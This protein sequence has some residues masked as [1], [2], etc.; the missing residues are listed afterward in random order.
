MRRFLLSYKF[1]IVLYTFIII[2]KYIKIIKYII[3]LF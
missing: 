2:L 3:K 1:N